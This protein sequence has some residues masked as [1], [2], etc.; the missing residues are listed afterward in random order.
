MRIYFRFLSR[1]LLNLK[2][3]LSLP[4]HALLILHYGANIHWSKQEKQDA[5]NYSLL[6]SF[7]TPEILFCVQYFSKKTFS[8]LFYVIY[9]IR[10]SAI[11]DL[12]NY[13]SFVSL[14]NICALYYATPSIT[15]H[16]FTQSR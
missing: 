7:A 10:T 9:P 8:D 2:G 1:S 5:E 4:Y 12:H 6:L 14:W 13:P 16:P 11:A 15:W 3:S